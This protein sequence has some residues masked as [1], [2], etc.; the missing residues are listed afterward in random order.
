MRLTE[1]LPFRIKD[2]DFEYHQITVRDGKGQKVHLTMLP[3]SLIEPLQQ[4][5]QKA[6]QLH[7][8]T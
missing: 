1:G 7:D 6:K 3:C 4:Q 2:L 8:K 5:L